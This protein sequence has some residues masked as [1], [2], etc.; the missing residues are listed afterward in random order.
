ML[1]FAEPKCKSPAF[2]WGGISAKRPL[3]DRIEVKTPR[4]EASI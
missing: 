3:F 4:G 1:G 2:G